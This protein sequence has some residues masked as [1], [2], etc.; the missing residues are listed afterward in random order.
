M[1]DEIDLATLAQH[2]Q[3]LAKAAEA[4]ADEDVRDAAAEVLAELRAR[5]VE[6]ALAAVA[7]AT[8][9]ATGGGGGGV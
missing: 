8:A 1:L 4:N 3:A 7:S 5:H 2:E 6:Q 9:A